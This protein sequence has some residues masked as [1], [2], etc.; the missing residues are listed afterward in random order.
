MDF[1]GEYVG[2]CSNYSESKKKKK[3]SL[4]LCV[5]SNTKTIYPSYLN[6]RLLVLDR[7]GLCGWKYQVNLF[8]L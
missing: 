4:L 8:S 1:L 3:K 5:N 7:C 6:S 2:G